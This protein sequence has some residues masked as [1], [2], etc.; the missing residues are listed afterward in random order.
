MVTPKAK[1]N[2]F[3]KHYASVTHHCFSPGERKTNLYVCQ[4]R[5]RDRLSEGLV[6]PESGDFFLAELRRVLKEA[7]KMKGAAG[8]DGLPTR[9][10]QNLEGVALDFVLDIFNESWRTGHSLKCWKDTVI[11]QGNPRESF[12]L[13]VQL[14][15]RLS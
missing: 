14:P 15:L 11:R 13:G 9:L 3:V 8:P 1:A 2:G 4:L 5:S 10:L 7:A 12:N 6:G